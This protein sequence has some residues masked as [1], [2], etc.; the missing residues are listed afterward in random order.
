[1]SENQAPTFILVDGHSLAFRSYFAFAKSRDGGLRTTTGIPTSVCFG[2]LKSLLEVMAA[3]D[4]QYMAIAFDLAAPTF[5]HEADET[6]KAGRAETPEDFKPDIK[7]L[8]ELLGYLNL[9]AVTAPGYEADDVLGTLA[10]KASAAGYAVKILTGDRD[11]FQLVETEK[12]ISVLYLSTDE[13]RRSGKGKSQEYGPEE[14][15]EKLG[16]LPAQVIDYKALCGDKSDNIPGVK[17][18]GDKT[19]LQLLKAY[20]TLDGIYAAID[21]IK[22]ATKK[23]LEEGKEAAYHS[24]KMA[25]I[26]QEVPLEINLEDCQLK[27]FDEAA[28]IPMLEK[29]EFKTFLSKVKQ[30]QKRFGGEEGSAADFVADVADVADVE[31]K[32]ESTGEVAISEEQSNANNSTNASRANSNAAEED[33]LWFWKKEDIPKSPIKPRI[34]QTIEQLNELIQLLQTFTDKNSPV[35]WDTE[36]TAIEPRDA[37]LVGIGCCWGTGEQDLAYIPT[38]HKTGTN[39]DKATVLNALRPILESENYPK[40]LQNAKFDR[41]I[42][43]C[44]GIKLAGVVF[45]T[46]LA[47]YVLNP[48]TSHS[49]S[50]LSRKYLGIVAESYKELVPKNKTIADISIIKVADYCGMDVHTTFLLVAKLKSELDEVDQANLPEKPLNDLLLEVEQPLEP[51][52]AEMEYCGIRIDS[53]YLNTLSHQ[54]EKSLAEIEE[55][56]YEAAGKKFNLGSPKQLSEILLEK[57]PEQFQ[58]KSRKTKTGYSTDAAVLDKLQGDHP[59][60]DDLL[61][62]RTLSKLKST[63]VDALPQLVRADTGRVH[64]DFN[65]AA[66]GTGRLSSSNPNL[67]NIPIRTEFSRQIRKAFLPESGW[68]MV[69]ADYSQIELRILAHLSQEPLLLE[70]Y[71]N[72]QD[73]HTLTAQLLFEKETITPDERRFGKTINFGVV[74]GMGAI[75]FGRSMGK[76]SADGKKFIERFNQRYSKVFEFLEKVKKEAIALGYVS[77]ILGRRRYLNFES[78]TIRR[79]KGSNPEDIHS[80]LLKSLTKNDAQSLRAAANAP[81]QGSSADIIKLA[82]IEVDKILQNYQAR[83]LLQVH[84]ELIFEVPPDEW[85]ELQPKIRTAMENA[86]PLSV[87]LIV[88]IHAGQNWMETK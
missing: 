9:P 81:I 53:A 2:F 67:Q 60:V 12:H 34:I 65:Q 48:E 31:K 85:E 29:L 78:D 3:H 59:I 50:E 57:I 55:N 23:K 37:E 63:Y 51:V 86:L 33:A 76:S 66:T 70:A 68:L 40:A 73:V 22:G 71:K 74:Y 54:L 20:N 47:S 32:R 7:N 16:I 41:S 56:T 21:D 35:A 1:M 62:H 27:G 87:P 38:G 75:K 72:N 17:G 64:T 61:E 80:S 4:P 13:L 19:A 84:D 58:K 26:I 6:Y 30:I 77:T 15:K 39:L 83:L 45:D 24:Q 25:T 49:L 42:L 11:L 82:M 28:L 18:I 52:L 44:Q 10:N 69:S 14:V 88:D 46:M 5:R 43:R 79:L 8:Q 36:T